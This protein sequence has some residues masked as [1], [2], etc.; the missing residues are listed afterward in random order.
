MKAGQYAFRDRRARKGDFRSLW[1]QRINAACRQHGMSYSVFIA[2]LKGA[3]VD[4]DRKSLADLA[5][6]DPEAFANYRLH[7]QESIQQHGGRYLVRGAQ[8]EMLGGEREPR[9]LIIV[10]FP[11]LEQARTWYRSAEYAAA[12]QF[13]DKALSRILTLV[14][15]VPASPG[16]P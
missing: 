14:D 6:R 9:M 12:L 10:E 3:G 7:A 15:G 11:S 4:I 5:V 2:G 16:T 8:P 1:I 13:R